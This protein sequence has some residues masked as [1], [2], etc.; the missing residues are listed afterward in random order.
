VSDS[1]TDHPAYAAIRLLNRLMSSADGSSVLMLSTCPPTL[2]K[3]AVRTGPGSSTEMYTPNSRITVAFHD[4]L[5]GEP[6][7]VIRVAERQNHETVAVLEVDPD[8]AR[9][10]AKRHHVEHAGF[11]DTGRAVAASRS[12]SAQRCRTPR[13]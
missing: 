12:A 4:A 13:Q 9:C 1:A 10:H 8:V 7:G 11:R 5:D 3:N 6:S 2:A